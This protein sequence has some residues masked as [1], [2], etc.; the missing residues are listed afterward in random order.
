MDDIER[1][2]QFFKDAHKPRTTYYFDEHEDIRKGPM[3]Y[4]RCM[5]CN[6]NLEILRKNNPRRRFIKF[7]SANCRKEYNRRGKIREKLGSDGLFW[8]TKNGEMHLSRNE[9]KATYVR[10]GQNPLE[11]PYKAKKSKWV[12]I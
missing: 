6:K 9:M 11:I 3:K 12:S 7:C 4:P 8:N 1:K 5:L 10:K 2:I